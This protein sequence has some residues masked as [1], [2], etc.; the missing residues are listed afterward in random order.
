M[1]N[2]VYK[3]YGER[4]N[5]IVFL[6]AIRTLSKCVVCCTWKVNKSMF[7]HSVLVFSLYL[8]NFVDTNVEQKLVHIDKNRYYINFKIIVPICNSLCSN[9]PDSA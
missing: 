5:Y 8:N 1:H 4:F 3:I 6:E 7:V 9:D 2:G